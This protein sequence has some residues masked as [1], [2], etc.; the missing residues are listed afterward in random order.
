[1]CIDVLHL[2]GVDTGIRTP[3]ERQAAFDRLIGYAAE[4]DWKID[5][6][7]FD[8]EELPAAWEAQCGSPGAKIII[9]VA[10]D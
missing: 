10:G 6:M 9:K 4:G 5:T 8:L 7:V 2:I 3:A 1:M